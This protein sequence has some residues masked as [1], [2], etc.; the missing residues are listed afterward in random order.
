M[1]FYFA[2]TTFIFRIN[3]LVAV[4]TTLRSVLFASYPSSKILPRNILLSYGPGDKKFW[5]SPRKKAQRVHDLFHTKL[6]NLMELENWMCCFLWTQLNTFFLLPISENLSE[7]QTF[8]ASN[9]NTLMNFPKLES[10]ISVWKAFLS[11]LQYRHFQHNFSFASNSCIAC[12]GGCV[13]AT[14]KWWDWIARAAV[15]SFSNTYVQRSMGFWLARETFPH[16]P[17]SR[18]RAWCFFSFHGFL[19]RTDLQGQQFP[20]FMRLF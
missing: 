5:I 8:S 4:P 19:L 13:W 6:H 20:L 10:H 16:S 15:P 11:I 3:L 1:E 9:T 18:L 14:W 2:E 7:T 17:I 12:R